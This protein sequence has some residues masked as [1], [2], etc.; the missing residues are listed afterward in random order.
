[1]PLQMHLLADVLYFLPDSGSPPEIVLMLF[2][3]E[4]A[5]K[6]LFLL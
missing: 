3:P 2:P 1:M 5:G 4:I 6:C